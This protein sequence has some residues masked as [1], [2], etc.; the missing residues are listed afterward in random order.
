MVWYQSLQADMA[1]AMPPNLYHLEADLCTNHGSISESQR[2]I[3][4]STS[5]IAKNR[6]MNHKAPQTS[7][8]SHCSIYTYNQSLMQLPDFHSRLYAIMTSFLHSRQ[9]YAHNRPPHRIVHG[10]G[11]QQHSYP[12]HSRHFV[13]PAAPPSGLTIE[14]MV[15]AAAEPGPLWFTS[16][17]WVEEHILVFGMW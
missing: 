8:I 4:K 5:L 14:L 10:I 15:D 16:G 2:T 7:N 1:S 11:I 9:S 13:F 12:S 17:V 3:E 6:I